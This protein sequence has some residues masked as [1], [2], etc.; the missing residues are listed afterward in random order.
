MSATLLA[1]LFPARPNDPVLINWRGLMRELDLRFGTLDGVSADWE[2]AA[3]QL[4]DIALTRLNEILGPAYD[5]LQNFASLGPGWILARSGTTA[6][7]QA[8]QTVTFVIDAGVQ[9]TM[10]VATLFLIAQNAHDP[11]DFALVRLLNYLPGSGT[12]AVQVVAALGNP[13]PHDRWII[14][15]APGAGLAVNGG[16]F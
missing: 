1:E 7:L 11:A 6:T 15:A 9:R 8:N 13:G 5:A 10:F 12:L 16:T 3:R 4:R 2:E 14:F